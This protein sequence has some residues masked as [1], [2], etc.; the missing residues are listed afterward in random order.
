M[1]TPTSTLRDEH[2]LIL[3]ALDLLEGAAARGARGLPIPRGWWAELIAWFRTFADSN[4]HAK[5]ERALFPALARAGVPAESGGPIAV[6]LEEHGEGRALIQSMAEGEAQ[7]QAAAA[8]RYIGLLR[9][10][11]D[12]ENTILFPLADE[13]LDEAARAALGRAFDT[14]EAEI[15]RVASLD[16]A[17]AVLQGLAAGL[18]APAE[19]TGAH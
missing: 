4:H 12:K 6:M 3:Q 7:T 17:A 9:A 14:V 15:G 5:E 18:P 1:K 10:H 13:L 16:Y 11:I 2:A 8:R 19:V